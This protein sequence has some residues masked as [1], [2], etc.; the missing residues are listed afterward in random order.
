MNLN[1]QGKPGSLVIAGSATRESGIFSRT[2]ANSIGNG[3]NIQIDAGAVSLQNN[4][5]I[6]AEANGTGTGG[7][8]SLNTTSLSVGKRSAISAETTTASNAGEIAVTSDRLTL[9]GGQIRAQ[10]RGKGQGGDVR[11][12]AKDVTVIGES[13]GIISGSGSPVRPG[14]DLGNGEIFT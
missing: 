9:E 12:Q 7:R 10:T 5:H 8:I 4:A 1:K 2:T 3:G 14:G 11:I 6:G 13:S